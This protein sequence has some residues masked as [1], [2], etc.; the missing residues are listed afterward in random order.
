M[1]HFVGCMNHESLLLKGGKQEG[2]RR[3]SFKDEDGGNVFRTGSF[4]WNMQI[5]ISHLTL[6][7]VT[8][9][10]MY[11]FCHWSVLGFVPR[12]LFAA[13]W[14]KGGAVYQFPQ[15]PPPRPYGSDAILSGPEVTHSSS[16]SSN[17]AGT[18]WRQKFFR[19]QACTA[20]QVGQGKCSCPPP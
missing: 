1:M 9:E 18:Y 14:M 8:R 3:K 20:L 12:K 2:E 16:L 10:K 15:T 4:I 13:G 17:R 19:N 5:Q 6:H 7:H 11:I